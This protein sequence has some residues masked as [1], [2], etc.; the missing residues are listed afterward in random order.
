[1]QDNYRS[2]PF[3]RL[4]AY[5]LAALLGAFAVGAIGLSPAPAQQSSTA[6]N[7]AGSSEEETFRQL[8]LFGDV[9]ERVRANYVEE[10]GEEKLIE[11]AISGMLSALDPHSTFLNKDSLQDMQVQTRGEFGGLGLEVT[12]ENGLVRVITPIDETPAAR[13]GLMA[14]DLIYEIDGQAIMGLS[15]NEAV[16]KMRGKVGS[17]VRLGIQRGEETFERVLKREIIEVRAVR[18]RLEGGNIGYLRITSFNEKVGVGVSEAIDNLKRQANGKIIGYIL[19]LRNNPGGLLDQAIAVT[20][21][22]LE[23]GEIVSTRGRREDAAARFNATKGDLSG[24]LPLVPYKI[25]TARFC[26]GPKALVRARYRRLSPCRGMW[27]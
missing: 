6:E 27:R 19:D 1:V 22:F 18:S 26:L 7:K 23:Q 25:I 17:E 13:A 5:S 21:A 3:L 14:G 15:L 24:G 16:D 9:F 12:M 8:N 11:N 10:V 20:D 4:S 2:K